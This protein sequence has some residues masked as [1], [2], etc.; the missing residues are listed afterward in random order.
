M[1]ASPYFFSSEVA[2]ASCDVAFGQ[3][4]GIAGTGEDGQS[5]DG[6]HAEE[7]GARKH[8]CEEI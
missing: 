6:K 1:M 4:L 7:A 5:Q 8:G 2:I 3:D